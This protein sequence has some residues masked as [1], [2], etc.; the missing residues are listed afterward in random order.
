GIGAGDVPD[1]VAVGADA[2]DQ[3]GVDEGLDVGPVAVN[4][5]GR[6]LKDAEGVAGS[7]GVVD[8]VSGHLRAAVDVAREV[9]V[10]IG[11]L[12]RVGPGAAGQAAEVAEGVAEDGAGVDVGD[13][14]R[15]AGVVA[16]QGA[17]GAAAAGV[18]AGKGV[19]VAEGA[20]DAGGRVVQQVDRHGGGAQAA[21]V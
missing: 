2:I 6:V 1:G 5:A 20:A 11:E 12:E 8:R 15:V 10:R 4:A 16:G 21:V 14:E 9:A 7:A 18:V 13:R 3:G 19:D 17:V